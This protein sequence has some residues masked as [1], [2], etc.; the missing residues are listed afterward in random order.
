M[1]P[2][3][4]NQSGESVRQGAR[5]SGNRNA[6]SLPNAFQFVD[7]FHPTLRCYQP[8]CLWSRGS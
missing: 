8:L 5:S 6:Q 4:S 7:S 1:L 2:Q 3:V